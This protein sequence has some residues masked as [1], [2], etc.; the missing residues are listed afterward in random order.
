MSVVQRVYDQRRARRRHRVDTDGVIW[1]QR[2]SRVSCT[3]RDLSR[4]GLGLV[5]HEAVS[6]PVEFDLTF[7]HATRRYVTVWRWRDR[8]GVKLKAT[9]PVSWR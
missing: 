2:H 4:S 6:L 3:V 8:I 1:L 9:L 7:D 5:V